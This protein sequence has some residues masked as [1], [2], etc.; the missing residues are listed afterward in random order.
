MTGPGL[1]EDAD[2]HVVLIRRKRLGAALRGL[3]RRTAQD[4]READAAAEP[5][6]GAG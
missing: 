2:V 3:F 5:V 4:V 1:P 6:R